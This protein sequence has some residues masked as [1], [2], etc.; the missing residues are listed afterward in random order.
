[1]EFTAFKAQIEA[2]HQTEVAIGVA[3]FRL[4]I[5][6]EHAWRLALEAN[7]DQ[8]GRLLEAKAYR[9]LL[10][11]AVVGWDGVKT[12]DILAEASEETLAFSPAARDA[13]L[14][15]RQDIADRLM[16]EMAQKRRDRLDRAEAARKNS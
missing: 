14:D 12:T 10:D 11:L 9:R 16:I 15:V 8:D 6:S 4:R 13:L 3:K 7:R 1:M 5:P 2:A